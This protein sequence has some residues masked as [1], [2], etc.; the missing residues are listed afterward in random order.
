MLI[1]LIVPQVALKRAA[2]LS[3]ILALDVG[4]G[5]GLLSMMAARCPDMPPAPALQILPGVHLGYAT[6]EGVPDPAD[7]LAC[8]GRAGADQVVAAEMSGHMADAGGEVVAAN[9]FGTRIMMVDKD[10]RRMD[11]VG[12]CPRMPGI[13][14]QSTSF[15]FSGCVL[16]PAASRSFNHAEQ[17][18]KPD[19]TPPDMERKADILV[20]EVSATIAAHTLLE[21]LECL[22]TCKLTSTSLEHEVFDAGLIGEGVL[23]ALAAARVKLVA[24]DAVLVPASATVKAGP[25]LAPWRGRAC[26]S[27]MFLF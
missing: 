1:D 27:R 3:H 11:V 9:G 7:V 14:L 22:C 21:T 8:Y 17:V 15:R 6:A 4:A 2:G 18:R 19:G 13:C 26:R 16:M 12:A 5:S 23:H 20:Y 24:P 10:A 25:S